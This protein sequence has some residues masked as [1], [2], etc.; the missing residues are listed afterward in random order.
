MLCA[1]RV[2]VSWQ[3]SMKEKFSHSREEEHEEKSKLQKPS[4]TPSGFVVSK[5]P[6]FALYRLTPAPQFQSES[7]W[8]CLRL[9]LTNCIWPS[10]PL[11][12]PSGGKRRRV[13]LPTRRHTRICFG[14]A[15]LRRWW[16]KKM[17]IESTHLVLTDSTV[18]FPRY[19]RFAF[20]QLNSQASFEVDSVICE[21]KFVC[22]QVRVN[23]HMSSP[24]PGAYWT[25]LLSRDVCQNNIPQHRT[26]LRFSLISHHKK[27]EKPR[28]SQRGKCR[29]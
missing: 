20:C 4:S 2:L 21:E 13:V 27:R 22:T 7:P 10:F 5:R 17:S 29:N 3:K 16:G 25:H 26:K 28:K 19:T 11:C 18:N 1:F 14:A 15:A 8:A 24:P 9:S 12:F 6:N 23:T